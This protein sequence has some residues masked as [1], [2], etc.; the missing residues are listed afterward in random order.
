MGW[1]CTD[2][3]ILVASLRLRVAGF[4]QGIKG[5]IAATHQ[6]NSKSPLF[7]SKGS[8]TKHSR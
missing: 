7:L 3:G 1:Y 8:K 5:K 2:R 6:L 4:N